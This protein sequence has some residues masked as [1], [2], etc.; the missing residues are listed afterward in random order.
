MKIRFQDVQTV[1]DL[2]ATQLYQVTRRNS[3]F[4][5]NAVENYQ[6]YGAVLFS[7]YDLGNFAEWDGSKDDIFQVEF[8]VTEYDVFNSGQ[9][10]NYTAAVTDRLNETPLRL[11][12]QFIYRDYSFSGRYNECKFDFIKK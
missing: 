8:E 6:K 10:A 9:A 5:A 7:R 3:N 4:R 11:V 12:T 1:S 2:D